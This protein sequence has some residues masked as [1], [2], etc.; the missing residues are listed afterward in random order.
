MKLQEFRDKVIRRDC[1]VQEQIRQQLSQAND[2]GLMRA[3][4]CVRDMEGDLVCHVVLVLSEAAIWDASLRDSL[5]E[6]VQLLLKG[7]DV[8]GVCW[9]R[10]QTEFDRDQESECHLL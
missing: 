7:L 2:D 9:F 10:T 6:K 1:Q 5:S 8:F 3:F 4:V